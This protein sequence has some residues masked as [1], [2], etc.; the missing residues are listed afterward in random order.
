MPSRFVPRG[1]RTRTP[2]VGTR[3]WKCL[4]ADAM[5]TAPA[6][7]TPEQNLAIAEAVALQTREEPGNG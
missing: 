3:R 5:S 6:K 7:R 4:V 2:S 1:T